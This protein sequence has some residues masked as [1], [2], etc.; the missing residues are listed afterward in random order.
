VNVGENGHA[1]DLRGK[2]F[3]ALIHGLEVRS[4]KNWHRRWSADQVFSR[5]FRRS[6]TMDAFAD[7]EV[8]FFLS[9][10]KTLYF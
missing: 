1:V 10:H 7:T 5:N 2:E 3:S 4:K 8:S 9:C 6:E